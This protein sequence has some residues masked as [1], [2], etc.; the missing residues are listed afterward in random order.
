M[1]RYFLKVDMRKPSV[2]AEVTGEQVNGWYLDND[3][4]VNLNLVDEK[5]DASTV[6]IEYSWKSDS[7]TK[8]YRGPITV[9]EGS[10]TLFYWATD[11]A[12]N[13]MEAKKID[14]K[15]DSMAPA[16]ALNMDGPVANSI[17]V[18]SEVII[19]LSSSTDENG[20]KFYSVDFLGS[21]APEWS[22]GVS[23]A[24]VYTEPGTYNITAQV[25]DNAGNVQQKVVQIVVNPVEVIDNST[26]AGS[27]TNS[28]LI[29]MGVIVIVVILVILIAA[30]IILITRKKDHIHIPHPHLGH[31]HH[32]HHQHHPPKNVGPSQ[33]HPGLKGNGHQSS[34]PPPPPPKPPIS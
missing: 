26:Q 3:I 16:L 23:F 9:P 22:A 11:L 31:H 14:F 34:L 27:E 1:L 18:G 12:G 2:I 19:D 30:L 25:K 33:A 5:E 7:E 15:K 4:K 20:V 13:G 21:S 8:I 6:K 24:H 28:D 10:S 32:G 29:I 17:D